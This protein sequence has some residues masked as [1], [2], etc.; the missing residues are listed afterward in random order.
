[1]PD[2][3]LTIDDILN[4]DTFGILDTKAKATQV[5]TDEDR[6][7]D[8]FEE[9]NVFLDSNHREPSQGS[10][11]EYSLMAR[12]KK[13]RNDDNIKKILKP[14]DRHNL[15]GCVEINTPTLDNVLNDNSGILD[16]SDDLSIFKYR[17][18]PKEEDRA[19]T[20]F[21]AKRKPLGDREF[22]PY[23]KMF[24]KVHQEI[25]D[26]KRK[27]IEFKNVDNELEAGRFYFIDG[28]MIY[29][30]STEVSRK[31]SN[32]RSSMINRKD[33]RTRTIFENG[34]VSN[35]YYRSVSKAIYNGGAKMVSE[36]DRAEQLDA[37]DTT[38][39]I[40]DEDKCSGWIYILKSKSQRP[41]IKDIKNLYKIGFSST[42]VKE[43]IK[44][45]KNEAAYLYDDVA[46]VETYQIYNLNAKKFEQ[47][48]HRVFA[49]ACLDIEFDTKDNL[50]V[51][52]REWFV[53]PKNVIE[54]AIQLIASGEIVNY[55]FNNEL[56]LLVQRTVD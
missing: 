41:E 37:F 27:I 23:E 33:G 29:L 4:D 32:L 28:V 47:L 34:T 38:E 40:N 46:I 17:H 26:G 11:S 16:T 12:L 8:E 55:K 52:P 15:L 20:D 49:S 2:K 35:M 44:N 22:A 6:L 56:Q 45:A 43:R 18:I 24:H 48:T 21:M 14:F 1:M 10:M 36:L 30:E 5:K 53:V 51:N 50:R 54:E 19:K 3:K 39:N 13:A 9:I 25:K 31:N 42:P 7:I